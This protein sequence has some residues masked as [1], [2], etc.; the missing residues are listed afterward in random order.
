MIITINN[1]QLNKY[2]PFNKLF[3]FIYLYITDNINHFNHNNNIIIPEKQF[4]FRL[5]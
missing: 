2:N 1:R 3:F 4:C 5:I